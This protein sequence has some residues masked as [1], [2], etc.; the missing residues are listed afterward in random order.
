VGVTY[1]YAMRLGL[2]AAALATIGALACGRLKP[3][4]VTGMLPMSTPDAGAPEVAAPDVLP[5]VTPEASPEV[6]PDPIPRSGRPLPLDVRTPVHILDGSAVIMGNGLDACTHQIPPSG[7]GHRWCAFTIGAPMNGLASLWVLDVSRAAAGDAPRCDGTD[8]GCLLLTDKVVTRSATFFEGDTLFYGT[9]TVD[10]NADFLGRIHAWRPGWSSGRQLTSDRGFT[11]IGHKHS[12][13]VA[14]FDDPAGDPAMRDSAEVRVGML[15]DAATEPLPAFGRAPLRNQGDP[16]WQA[17]FSQD[18]SLFLLANADTP[19]T[20]PTLLMSPT[21]PT[22]TPA[23]SRALDDVDNWTISNDGQKI[24]FLR[25]LRDLS[26][27]GDLFVADFPSFANPTLIESEIKYYYMLIGERTT[28]LAIELIKNRPTGGAIELLSDRSTTTPKTIFTFDD[29]LNGAVV[30]PDLKYTTWLND[31]FKGVVF[32]N[33]D[34]QP[35]SINSGKTSIYKPAYLDD[36]SLMFWTEIPPGHDNDS[37]RDAYFAPPERCLEKQLFAQHVDA[38]TPIGDRGLVYTDELDP[39]TSLTTLK[40]IATTADRAA[41]D[42]AGA[43]RV[44]E[45]VRAPFVLVG[46]SPP[47]VVYGAVGTSADTTGYYVFGPVPF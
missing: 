1:T 13:A 19:G 44:H 40:Y 6:T 10:P 42:P 29:F 35:C 3:G 8:P 37:I 21:R 9:D 30:S 2:G 47:L 14:C 27:L 4:A 16:P 41:L 33:S 38:F 34:L 23:L 31:P 24:Y 17:G 20:P 22:G 18:G 26:Q 7:D 11:C 32:R 46:P 25:N 36:A 5:E 28:D 12:S 15:D 43:V 39:A 45:N